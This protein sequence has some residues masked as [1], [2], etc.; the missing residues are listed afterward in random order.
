MYRSCLPEEES[1]VIFPWLDLCCY[2]YIS[3]PKNS[4]VDSSLRCARTHFQ[5][6]LSY[7]LVDRKTSMYSVVWFMCSRKMGAE[8]AYEGISKFNMFVGEEDTQVGICGAY[9]VE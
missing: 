9:V 5:V 4:Q 8:H 6:H 7:T 2:G 1:E 3:S